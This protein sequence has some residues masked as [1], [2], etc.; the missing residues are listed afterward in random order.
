MDAPSQQEIKKESK[1]IELFRVSTKVKP[2][3][4]K[5]H[6]FEVEI[7][8]GFNN[9]KTKGDTCSSIATTEKTE[10]SFFSVESTQAE[11]HLCEKSLNCISQENPLRR[12]CIYLLSL[13]VFNWS[14]HIL[15]ILNSIFLI[16]ETIERLERVGV[17]SNYIF[18]AIFTIECLMQIIALGFI[19]DDNAYLRDPWNWLDFIVVITGLLSLLPMF[20]ANLRALRTFR[21]IRPLKAISML[22]NMRLFIYTLFDSMLDLGV[23]FLLML[24]FLILFAIIGLSLWSEN[25]HKRCRARP[26]TLNTTL[27]ENFTLIANKY[28]F[29]NGSLIL[30]SK[31][32][33]RLCGGVN[34]CDGHKDYCVNSMD[35]HPQYLTKHQVNAENKPYADLNYGLT[36]YEN[37]VQS[38]FIV[39]VTT[40][41]EGKIILYLIYYRMV[42]Y[43]ANDY[44]FS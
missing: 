26:D 39:F 41:C 6:E 30:D 44:G 9:Q 43:D 12:A 11:K 5:A 8:S 32:S 35:Y 42:Q 3:D 22:P 29:F 34:D 2:G 4:E 24:F 37:I 27:Y 28:P 18:T 31:F 33:Q 21:L 16:F 38:L 17:I 10:K 15:I 1:N 23:V 36:N 40:N 25:F 13:K 19:M 14:I 7:E 20:S